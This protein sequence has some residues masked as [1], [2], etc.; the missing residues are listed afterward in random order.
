[1]PTSSPMPTA[2]WQLP[3]LLRR[4]ALLLP[5]L[6]LSWLAQ[7]QT[8]YFNSGSISYQTDDANNRLQ[9]QVRFKVRE[10]ISVLTEF[11]NPVVIGG[12][13]STSALID[14]GDGT[15]R[16]QVNL[17]VLSKGQAAGNFNTDYFI[18]EYN[19]THTYSSPGRYFVTVRGENRTTSG[20]VVLATSA[21]VGAGTTNDSP[22]SL[23]DPLVLL[24]RTQG[25]P[26]YQVPASDPNG[27]A[28][29]YSLA[30]AE[31]AGD[32]S[33]RVNP[34]GLSINPSTGV[35]SFNTANTAADDFYTAVI[36]ISDGSTLIVVDQLIR[37]V[38]TY[39]LCDPTA[40]APVA[41][42]DQL[43]TAT[44][45]PLTFTAAQLLANDTDPRRRPLQVASVG[46]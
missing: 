25:T 17:T 40:T 10:I 22:V 14:F 33:G 3:L 37:L 31:E 19:T 5:L 1:M 12:V 2:T 41:V 6:C 28:L 23:P 4:V 34:A 9:P 43:S 11:R 30:T 46:R 39:S 26:T 36:K 20:G 7:A 15:P 24:D 38:G 35:L 32:A 13:R 16:E 44:G 29:T 21:V 45:S 18:G 42:A 27:D 8:S